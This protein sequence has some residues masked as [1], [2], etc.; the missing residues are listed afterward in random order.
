MFSFF[1]VK[2]QEMTVEFIKNGK[3]KELKDDFKIYFLTGDS[4]YMVI[5]KPK[6]NGNSFIMPP[7]NVEEAYILFEYGNCVYNLGKENVIFKQKMK[8]SFGFDTKPYDREYHQE[9]IN[10]KSAEGVFYLEFHPQEY[11]DGVVTTITFDDT[12][13]FLKSGKDLIYNW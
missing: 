10:R 8:W 5:T 2:S 12:K 11:G 4:T 7:M 6:I 9:A 3:Q 13:Q 1:T